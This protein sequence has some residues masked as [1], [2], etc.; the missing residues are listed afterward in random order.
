MQQTDMVVTLLTV[1]GT[2]TLNN[3]PVILRYCSGT[4]WRE[5]LL[6]EGG[7]RDCCLL[8]LFVVL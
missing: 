7:R 6:D 3:T 1:Q 5:S 4:R 8:S 2:S